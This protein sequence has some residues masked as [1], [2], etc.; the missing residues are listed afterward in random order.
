MLYKCFCVCWDYRYIQR[1]G[2]SKY[3]ANKTGKCS[4][5]KW[6]L[7]LFWFCRAVKLTCLVTMLHKALWR[8]PGVVVS[9][10]AFHTRLRGSFPGLGGLKETKMFRLHSLVKLSIVGS[11]RD[12]EVLSVTETPHNT[13][14]ACSASDL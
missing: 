4:L 9:T 13:Q 14:V 11:L 1:D 12:R 2:H 10:A 5:F 6:A 7:S 3:G 8:G